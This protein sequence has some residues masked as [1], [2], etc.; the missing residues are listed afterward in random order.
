M[1]KVLFLLHKLQS[2][3]RPIL[4]LVA[5]HHEVTLLI[6]ESQRDELG[7]LETSLELKFCRIVRSRGLF[8]HD[9]KGGLHSFCSNYDIVIG[10]HNLRCVDIFSLPYRRRN[11]KIALW[12]IGVSGSYTKPFGRPS[13]TEYAKRLLSLKA[14]ALIFYTDYPRQFYRRLGFRNS[15][16]FAAHN[17]VSNKIP[18][19]TGTRNTITF[20]G[21]LY[22]EK[23]VLE[24]LKQ[25]KRAYAK[26]SERT[27]VLKII[28]GGELFPQVCD[29]ISKNQLTTAFALGPIFN[30]TELNALL[31]SSLM[32]ISPY[33]AGLSVLHSMSCGTPFITTRNAITGGEILNIT[34]GVNGRVLATIDELAAVIEDATNNPNIYTSMGENAYSYYNSNRTPE[35]MASGLISCIGALERP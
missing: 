1:A 31:G 3:R 25:Y 15:R 19:P 5:Q 32:T 20:V 18:F 34:D 23:G 30:P 8:T 27:P 24:L 13:L 33:Q 2:Y 12:G 4:E 6:D 16:L 35:I 21:T 17:T 10:L 26:L 11:Y 28:G 22:K 7:Q 14:D 29:F 9:I